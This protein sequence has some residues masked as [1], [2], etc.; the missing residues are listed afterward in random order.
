MDGEE[1]VEE[2]EEESLK[3]RLPRLLC[4]HGY[5]S[6]AEITRMQVD[7]LG[8]NA[9][10]DITYLEGPIRS[11][12]PAEDQRAASMLS[13]GPYFS[14]MEC[15]SEFETDDKNSA[16][17]ADI[18]QLIQSLK[19]ILVHL[20]LMQKKVRALNSEGKLIPY[21]DAVYG[22]SQGGIIATILS[23][24][25]LVK[26]LRYEFAEEFRHRRALPQVDDD[27]DAF[28]VGD[29]FER[30]SV[31][32]S[33]S[34]SLR[35]SFGTIDAGL[36]RSKSFRL[37]RSQSD[38]FL[39]VDADS[40]L[41]VPTKPEGGDKRSFVKSFRSFREFVGGNS[42]NTGPPISKSFREIC[43]RPT[44]PN[45]IIRTNEADID[46]EVWNSRACWSFAFVAC[47]GNSVMIKELERKFFS[48]NTEDGEEEC[49]VLYPKSSIGSVHYIGI[50]DPLKGKGEFV[51]NEYFQGEKVLPVYLNGRHEIPSYRSR[52][53][54]KN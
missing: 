1:W 48:V 34:G 33:S 16:G 13:E 53:R 51:M 15:R 39:R 25:Q 52:V 41:A 36:R 9:R 5:R 3:V 28:A 2:E 26:A 50:N 31:N 47:V 44:L 46:E 29:D 24:G 40:S 20:E 14:W 11:A 22:F 38:S 45:L 49:F 18:E 4:L 10:F 42:A 17:S 12:E 27:I 37:D 32:E 7:N 54:K 19:Y 8:L 6:N 30:A 23:H 43:G 21:Y 35:D